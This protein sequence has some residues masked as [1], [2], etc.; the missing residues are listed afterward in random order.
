[1]TIQAKTHHY[2]NAAKVIEDKISKLEMTRNET[3]EVS[4]RLRTK[5]HEDIDQVFDSIDAETV[6]FIG[7]QQ[8]DL[9]GRRNGSAS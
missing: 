7:G 3:L 1:M 6:T 5:C 4:S 2:T 9:E 8:S